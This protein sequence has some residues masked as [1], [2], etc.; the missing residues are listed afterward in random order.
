MQIDPPGHQ[1]GK[2]QEHLPRAASPNLQQDEVVRCDQ[3]SREHVRPRVQVRG[4]QDEGQKAETECH[5][6]GHAGPANRQ[7]DETHAGSETNRRENCDTG[8]VRKAVGSRKRHL[9]KPLERDELASSHGVRED[10]DARYVAVLQNEPAKPDVAAGIAVTREERASAQKQR[11]CIGKDYQQPP[12][13]REEPPYD[14]VG[15]L[16]H[17]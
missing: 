17:A 2:K 6:R 9:G 10:I 5:G 14:S 1:N 8:Q 12:H 11:E 3:Q 4:Q 7:V 16:L 15:S 13:C